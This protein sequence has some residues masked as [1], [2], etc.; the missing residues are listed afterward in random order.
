M[1]RVCDFLKES[2]GL[3]CCPNY[4]SSDCP[5]TMGKDN[6]CNVTE[7]YLLKILSGWN[8]TN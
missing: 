7:E 3:D 1:N 5:V 4:G 6:Q 8:K 2:Y